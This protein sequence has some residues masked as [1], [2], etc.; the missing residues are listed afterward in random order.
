MFDVETY[1]GNTVKYCPNTSLRE[2]LGQYFT[3]DH[4]AHGNMTVYTSTLNNGNVEILSEWGKQNY[5]IP[6]S[7]IISFSSLQKQKETI[8]F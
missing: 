4:W 2:I 6:P 5:F 1:P 3:P 7:T 8:L